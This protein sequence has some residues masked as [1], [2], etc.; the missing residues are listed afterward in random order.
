M[1]KIDKMASLGTV[2]IVHRFEGIR[3]VLLGCFL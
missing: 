2:E 1:N 3:H